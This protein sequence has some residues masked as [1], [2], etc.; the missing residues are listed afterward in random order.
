M[1][2]RVLKKSDLLVVKIQYMYT[3]VV[4]INLLTLIYLTL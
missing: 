2:K 3:E 1:T 4:N